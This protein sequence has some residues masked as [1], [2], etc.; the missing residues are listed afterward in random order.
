MVHVFF[1][2]VSPASTI[3]QEEQEIYEK[4]VSV[5]NH[6]GLKHIVAHLYTVLVQHHAVKYAPGLS[7]AVPS[8]PHSVLVLHLRSRSYCV[9]TVTEMC[10]SLTA[11]CIQI[12]LQHRVK[13][14][15]HWIVT[16]AVRKNWTNKNQMLFRLS[17][18]NC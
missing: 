7:A 9:S 17:F 3:Y 6:L 14:K 16:I 4:L 11:V 15:L 12:G 8:S 1:F 2:P 5:Q 18:S 10:N 13:R